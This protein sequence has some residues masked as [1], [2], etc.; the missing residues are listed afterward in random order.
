M[1]PNIFTKFK[2]K[3]LLWIAAFNK[4]QYLPMPIEWEKKGNIQRRHLSKLFA[5]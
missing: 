5:I 1:V 2:R 4:I 3:D